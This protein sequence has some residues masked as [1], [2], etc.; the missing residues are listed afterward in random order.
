[1]WEVSLTSV[2]SIH[3]NNYEATVS[4][5]I[6]T[7]VQSTGP[8]MYVIYPIVYFSRVGPTTLGNNFY[9][10]KDRNDMP[11]IALSV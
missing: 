1:M 9:V 6:G 11:Y 5:I 4:I 2:F 8:F 10:I 7:I 3:Y